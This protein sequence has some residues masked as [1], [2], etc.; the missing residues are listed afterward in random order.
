MSDQ[1]RGILTSQST[2]EWYTPAWCIELVNEVI[3]EIDLDPASSVQANEVI[4]AKRFYTSADDG[5]IKSWRAKTIFL[6]PPYNGKA[7]EWTQRAVYTYDV[8]ACNEAILLVFAKIGYNWFNQ[9]LKGFPTC[10]VYE[11]IKFTS[12]NREIVGNGQAKHTSAFVYL[13]N[14]SG[15]MVFNRVFSKIGCMTI[16]QEDQY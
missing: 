16:P 14:I 8:N 3:G 4:K 9:L 1:T 12:P 13:G 5:L 15:G 2:D 10:L 7:G 11:R 6:N